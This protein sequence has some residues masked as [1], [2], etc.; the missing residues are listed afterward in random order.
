[1]AYSKFWLL[2]IFCSAA[3]AAVYYREEDFNELDDSYSSSSSREDSWER[4]DSSSAVHGRLFKR[5]SQLKNGPSESWPTD[6]YRFMT[7]CRNGTAPW[8]VYLVEGNQVDQCPN[9]TVALGRYQNYQNSTGWGILEVETFPGFSPEMQ[10]YAAGLV[11]G[12]LTK[13]Q[14]FTH[15]KNTAATLCKNATEYCKRLYR[16][17][18]EHLDWV[19]KTAIQQPEEDLYW[20]QVNLTFYQLTGLNDGYGAD[21]A[22]GYFARVNYYIT[23]IY[24]IQLYGDY[25]D[26]EHVLNKTK[27][28]ADTDE[29]PGHCSGYV[30]VTEGNKDL[31]MSQVAMSGFNTMNRIVK[32]YKFA[33]DPKEVP[34]HTVTFSGYPAALASADDF[35]LTSGGLL[36]IETTIAVFNE[37]LYW[38]KV[39]PQEQL[40]CWIRSYIANQLTATA[41]D[42]V[43]LFARYNS[44]TY[45]NQWTVV[46]YKMFKPG[47]QLPSAD[48]IW[49]LE[50]IPGTT[51]S[52]DVT[53]FLRKYGYWP[54]Y[55]IPYLQKIS[56]LSGFNVKGNINNWWRWGYTPRARMFQ[57]DQAKVNDT[58]SLRALMRYNDYQHDEFSRCACKPFPYTAEAAISTRGDLNPVNGTWE[59]PGMSFR[60]HGSLDY[61]GTN[62]EMF[63]QLRFEL[64]GGPTYGGPGQL[65]PFDWETTNVKDVPHWGQPKLWKF[66]PFVTL[67]Q[68][69]ASGMGMMEED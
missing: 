43:K 19:R 69:E 14:I 20:R 30:K 47:Q 56:E 34:G 37:Q 48:L 51:V 22:D 35:T 17:L 59:V 49:I 28:K 26:L 23:P 46:D 7:V 11:E 67:W 42:W 68:T 8:R 3:S 1:M 25:F 41:H 44:G 66:D 53:W 2:F 18:S 45:N 54:S 58:D 55:N 39:K 50:Q 52:R 24:L 38:T 64:I 16:Y 61:K 4:P 62:Y 36:S 40:H 13:V 31:L 12:Q 29:D 63:K 60:N 5:F 6:F 21:K 9:G 65:P 27:L 57:R 15:F 33:Y 32:L 10:A